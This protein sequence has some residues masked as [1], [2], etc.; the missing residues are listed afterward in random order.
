[1]TYQKSRRT[2]G[3]SNLSLDPPSFTAFTF[4]S[5][6]SMRL[7]ISTGDRVR[8]SVCPCLPSRI[9]FFLALTFPSSS[10][11]WLYDETKWQTMSHEFGFCIH[12]W[13]L[14]QATGPPLAFSKTVVQEVWGVIT[15]PDWILTLAPHLKRRLNHGGSKE[16]PWVFS[17]P[18]SRE[19]IRLCDLIRIENQYK[20][21]AEINA[22]C[23]QNVTLILTFTPLISVSQEYSLWNYKWFLIW[24]LSRLRNC[25]W[26]V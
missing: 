17:F 22:R 20:A 6:F 26:I 15:K 11:T 18:D 13:F 1:M 24:M 10:L 16:G 5:L 25:F 12:P 21:N 19:C 4:L 9:C 2:L 3:K 7:R 8:P 14:F 23:L